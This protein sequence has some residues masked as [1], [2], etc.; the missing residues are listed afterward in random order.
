MLQAPTHTAPPDARRSPSS[1][2]RQRHPP[3]HPIPM[4]GPYQ[5]KRTLGEGEFGKVKLAVHSRSNAEVA[6][7]LCKKAQVLASPNG[8]VKLMREISTLKQ[9]KLHPFIITLIEVIETDIYIAIVMELAKGGELFEHILASRYLKEDESRRI[10]AEIICAV[11]YIHSIGIV[12]RDL[13]LE[14]ILL[15]ESRGVLVTDFGFA[16]K[17]KGPEGLLRTSCGSPCYAAPELVTR[18]GYVGESADIWSCGVILY[19]MIAGYL[20]F[21]DDPENPDGDNINLLYNYI[22]ETKLEYPDYVPADCRDLIDRILVPDPK[23]RA[24][25]N[26][27]MNHH[28][29]KPVK[30]IFDAEMDRRKKL[31]ITLNGTFVHRSPL[32]S[33]PIELSNSENGAAPDMSV[34]PPPYVEKTESTE[35]LLPPQISV[36]TIEESVAMEVD[37]KP[38]NSPLHTEVTQDGNDGFV[39]AHSSLNPTLDVSVVDSGTAVGVPETVF[40]DG[41]EIDEVVEQT[42]SSVL[43]E[44]SEESV[45]KHYSME[46]DNEAE[47]LTLVIGTTSDGPLSDKETEV[48]HFIQ[49]DSTT[50]SKAASTKEGTIVEDSLLIETVN[51][52][53]PDESV[54]DS[55][56]DLNFTTAQPSTTTSDLRTEQVETPQEQVETQQ[57][58]LKSPGNIEEQLK[59]SESS[60][61]HEK[62]SVPENHQ[63]NM[64]PD[65]LKLVP[66]LEVLDEKPLPPPPPEDEETKQQVAK[67]SNAAKSFFQEF[68]SS[69]RNRNREVESKGILRGN[70]DTSVSTATKKVSITEPFANNSSQIGSPSAKVSSDSILSG[71]D[72]TPTSPKVSRSSWLLA[73]TQRLRSESPSGSEKTATPTDA[74]RMASTLSATL[75]SPNQDSE[76]TVPTPRPSRLSVEMMTPDSSTNEVPQKP[77]EKH[78]GVAM[79]RQETAGKSYNL[80]NATRRPFTPSPSFRTRPDSSV[81]RSG[82]SNDLQAMGRSTTAFSLSVSEYHMPVG[83]DSGKSNRSGDS[84]WD[85]RKMRTHL[86]TVDHRAISHRHPESLLADL[87]SMFQDRGFSV[88]KRSGPEGGEYRLKVVRPGY[89]A[90]GLQR[91]PDVKD[92]TVDVSLDAL[93]KFMSGV[94]IPAELLNSEHISE[95]GRVAAVVVPLS[96]SISRSISRNVKMEQ[97]SK[98]G[99]MMAGLPQSLSKKVRYVK[100]YGINYNQGFNGRPH[101]DLQQLPVSPGQ[102]PAALADDAAKADVPVNLAASVGDQVQFV[103]EIVFYVELQKLP[104]VPRM[105]VVDMK[106]LRGN[107]WAFKKLYNQLV[108]EM[109]LV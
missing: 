109:P 34:S 85:D 83:N 82:A 25:I 43:E 100:E 15:D 18:D 40:E 71:A 67:R 102:T 51:E 21:D 107:I 64:I 10:F 19:S 17:S 80:F 33:T 16:N 74:G 92:G 26:E 104:N 37:P 12:H 50:T 77:A 56:P 30:H 36:P 22:M 11:G 39:T 84:G 101:Q 96:P 27:I 61:I 106:R 13:K 95:N 97:T 72:A 52:N 99:R 6:I 49:N 98:L 4:L 9:V 28:W 88:E 45:L 89:L 3:H 29:M 70:I 48:A 58:Q 65:A 42:E 75:S 41:M 31:V 103:D 94:T 91:N 20:P 38:E 66:R 5:L 44:V 87:V 86:G 2:G 90:R 8:Y 14:N 60:G 79:E 53:L 59:D 47:N 69:T 23:F 76:Y 73:V 81:T 108:Q 93:V 24:D 32:K 54:S 57:E 35:S 1:A 46:V 62:E 55:L 63:I 68:I 7:K 78:L 105:C